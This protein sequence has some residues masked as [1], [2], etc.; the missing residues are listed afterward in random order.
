MTKRKFIRRVIISTI[1]ILIVIAANIVRNNTMVKS[2]DVTVD[3]NNSE[4]L[5]SSETLQRELMKAMPT[6]GS[7][8]VK[9]VKTHDVAK[10]VAQSPYIEKVDT[11]ISI[12]CKVKIKA[13]QRQP[14]LHVFYYDDEFYLDDKGIYIPTSTE[15][16]ANVMV[17]SGHF[18]QKYKQKIQGLDIE[19]MIVDSVQKDYDITKMWQIAKYLYDNEQYRSLFDQIYVNR[20]NDIELVPKMGNHIVCVG[21]AND[22]EEKMKYLYALYKE[23]FPRIGWNKYKYIDLTYKGQAICRK[24]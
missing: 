22:I 2:V 20:A 12:S 15:G 5:V 3:Y 16:T 23:A 10:I 18:K 14:I 1:L 11:Y 19:K 13:Y 24:R 21:D 9:E 8:K 17:G 7:I 4:A 6:L